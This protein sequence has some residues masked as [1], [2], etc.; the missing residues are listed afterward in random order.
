MDS[1]SL[2]SDKLEIAVVTRQ[3]AE[4]EYKILGNAHIDTVLKELDLSQPAE[5][6]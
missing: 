6:S 5:S 2:S 4:L 1:T 3:D